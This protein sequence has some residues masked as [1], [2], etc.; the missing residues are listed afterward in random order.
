MAFPD[1]GANRGLFFQDGF[2]EGHLLLGH[3][4]QLGP[5]ATELRRFG[6]VVVVELVGGGGGG[7]P[8]GRDD[9]GDAV[10]GQ[11]PDRGGLLKTYGEVEPRHGHAVHEVDGHFHQLLGLLAAVVA[12]IDDAAEVPSGHEGGA[13]FQDQRPRPAS[14]AI[15]VEGLV[16]Q[17]DVSIPAGLGRL[18]DVEP[19]KRLGRLDLVGAACYESKGID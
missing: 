8:R 13:L 11:D 7:P 5:Q 6:F 12:V 17:G 18:E 14:M 9:R 10:D 3:V 1:L 16:V 19:E 4:L 15:L 2:L